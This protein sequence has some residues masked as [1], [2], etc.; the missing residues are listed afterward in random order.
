MEENTWLCT[1][2]IRLTDV[3][4]S[5]SCA[6]KLVVLTLNR[7]MKT[8][9]ASSLQSLPSEVV[10]AT[11]R[12]AIALARR[13][14]GATSPNPP[15]GCVLLDAD[16]RVIATGSH[17]RAGSPHAE[18]LALSVARDA[19]RLGRLHTLV[20]TLEP[21]NHHGRTPPCAEAILNAP[22]REIW[23]ACRDPNPSVVG[24]G[25]ERLL[26]E[27]R[28]VRF[29]SALDHPSAPAVLADA[30]RLLAPFAKRTLTGRP[31]VTLKQA[32]SLTGG[33]IPPPGQKTFTSAASLQLAHQLRRRADAI[34]TGSGT[35]LAD[36]PLLTVRH[37]PDHRG[38]QRL[39]VILDRRRRVPMAYTE[40]ARRSGFAVHVLDTLD[41][42][43]DLVGAAGGLEVLVEAGPSLTA[44]VL[45]RELWDEHVLFEQASEPGL[46]D[47]V[48]VRQRTFSPSPT[49]EVSGVFRHY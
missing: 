47:R 3:A 6:L 2:A 4:C 19:G 8:L 49:A 31:F 36:N 48:T 24:G 46:E 9:T 38:K 33:M 42:A 21:C 34:L 35:I 25:A 29:L 11:F 40:Q 27:G 5:S 39:L 43:L 45:N 7:A 13:H 23:I 1:R 10:L 37:V 32:L 26:A 16:G 12:Q 18:A 14:E 17:H 20:V 28:T 44:S 15:V 41:D 22:A 30:V